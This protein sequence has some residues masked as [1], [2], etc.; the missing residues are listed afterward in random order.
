MGQPELSLLALLCCCSSCANLK[1]QLLGAHPLLLLNALHSGMICTCRMCCRPVT[2]SSIFRWSSC[3]SS[4]S[5]LVWSGISASPQPWFL[6]FVQLRPPCLGPPASSFPLSGPAA[7]L[8]QAFTPLLP[9]A[10]PSLPFSPCLK[11]CFRDSTLLLASAGSPVQ[12]HRS[13]AG[14]HSTAHRRKSETSRGGH[15]WQPCHQ[16][17]RSPPFASCLHAGRSTH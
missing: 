16:N 8:S 14:Q 17:A 4:Q 1:C 5:Q 9:P 15:C 13:A 7:C 11:R 10:H 2:G 12:A 3:M 6:V